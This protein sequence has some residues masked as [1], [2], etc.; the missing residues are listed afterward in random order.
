MASLELDA[1]T[2]GVGQLASGAPPQSAAKSA[3]GEPVKITSPSIKSTAAS[4]RSFC[5]TLL[6]GHYSNRTLLTQM[7]QMTA[8][9]APE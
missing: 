4:T 3:A 7:T 6:R 9:L 2:L 1:F 5:N 8:H